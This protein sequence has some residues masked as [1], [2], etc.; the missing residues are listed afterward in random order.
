MKQDK[1]GPGDKRGEILRAALAEFAKCGY[2][3][4]STND[5]I[6]KAGV[7]KGL[8][9]HYFGSK[10]G[11]FLCVLDACINKYR[12]EFDALLLDLPADI[13]ERITLFGKLKLKLSLREPE[14]HRLLTAAFADP[15]P[16]LK[17]E[18]MTRQKQLYSD[19]APLMY[20][21][22]DLSRFRAGI[23]PQKAIEL[24]MLVMDTLSE[25]YVNMY[26]VTKT[27]SLDLA[28]VLQE[29]E[30]YLEMLKYGVYRRNEEETG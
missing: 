12:S 29:A 11:L 9:F 18:I 7:A 30:T 1:T 15:P 10:K 26:R 17:E 8:L 21:N 16:E 19:Y 22:A 20:R 14:I 27:E 2:D 3:Q 4:A 6:E 28:P 23:D 5:I 13:F 25:K 24:V